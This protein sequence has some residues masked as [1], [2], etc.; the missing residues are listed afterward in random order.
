PFVIDP[1]KCVKCYNCMDLCAFGA[2][3]EVFVDA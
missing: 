1:E 2:I 3:R